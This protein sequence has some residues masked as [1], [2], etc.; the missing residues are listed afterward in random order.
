[1]NTLLDA[2][3]SN[4]SPEYFEAGA[5]DMDFSEYFLP[6]GAKEQDRLRNHARSAVE[7]LGHIRDDPS[8]SARH[9][10][11]RVRAFDTEINAVGM[12]II[13]SLLANTA[14]GEDNE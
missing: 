3:I 5:F 8:Y 9:T 10:I 4:D 7:W 14:H 12:I 11:N 2:L 6:M 1:M 13:R